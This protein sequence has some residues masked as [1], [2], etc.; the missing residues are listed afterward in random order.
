MYDDI[1]QQMV[2]ADVALMLPEAIWMILHGDE[3]YKDDS[4]GRKVTHN[5]INP[6]M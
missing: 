4:F 2:E 6:S 1:Y 5:L 3:V